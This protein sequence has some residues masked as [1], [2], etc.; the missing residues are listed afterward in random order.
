MIIT[1]GFFLVLCGCSTTEKVGGEGMTS[2]VAQNLLRIA[3]VE[4]LNDA[5]WSGFQGQSVHLSFTG[6]RDSRNEP[7]L[8]G[9]IEDR[10]ERAGGTVVAETDNADA[11]LEVRIFLAGTDRGSSR[12]PGVRRS[13]RNESTVDLELRPRSGGR[14]LDTQSLFA[15]SKYEQSV[16][17]GFKGRGTYFVR[18]REGSFRRISDTSAYR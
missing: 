6:A 15:V 17:L 9:L 4:A 3:G 13:E 7:V 12:I 5:D 2:A 8:R 16:T 18:G 1:I 10:L 11:E 14:S